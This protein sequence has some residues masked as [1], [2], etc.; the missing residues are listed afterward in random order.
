[1]HVRRSLI[2]SMR[3]RGELFNVSVDPVA[4]NIPDYYERVPRPM[5]EGTIKGRLQELLYR[6]PEAFAADVRLGV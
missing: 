4:Q 1:V 6:E 5:D 3:N 2:H